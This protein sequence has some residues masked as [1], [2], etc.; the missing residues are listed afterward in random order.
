MHRV[1]GPNNLPCRPPPPL[2]SVAA[3]ASRRRF[4][5]P[6]AAASSL[7]SPPLL[8]FSCRFYSP[9]A[10][11]RCSHQFNR[12]LAVVVVRGGCVRESDID[13]WTAVGRFVAAGV[14]SCKTGWE[15]GV[16]EMAT[17]RWEY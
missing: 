13:F 12:R 8:L 14:A 1:F 7:L 10:A 15:A 16:A 9:L 17:A 3:L 5:S 6:L 11:R 4:Y 2:A